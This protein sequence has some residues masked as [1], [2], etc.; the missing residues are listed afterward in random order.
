MTLLRHHSRLLLAALV[1]GLSVPLAGQESNKPVLSAAGGA[2]STEA[3]TIPFDPPIGTPLTYALRFERKRPGGDSVYE[4]EQRLTFARIE[5]GLLL[6]LETLAFIIGGQR[7]DLADCQVMERFPAA[8]RPYL[9]PMSV[10]LDEAGEMVR[11]RDWEAMRASLRELPDAAVKLSDVSDEAAGRAALAQ[12]L[13]PIINA[14]AEDAPA[15]MI[16][17]WPSVLGFGG[18]EVDL[19]ETYEAESEVEGGLLPAS[20]PAVVQFTVTRTPEGK[21]HLF[22]STRYDPE[23]MRAATNAVIDAARAAAVGADK[24]GSGEAFGAMQASDTVDIA[25]DPSSGM[26]ITAEVLRIVS[27]DTGS[28]SGAGGEVMTISRIA[29]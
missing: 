19:G 7:L 16:R 3:V 9:L 1:L 18:I 28:E 2:E 25:L 23:A 6:R 20:I 24:S 13:G 14:S 29:P 17:G 22:Q 27:V 26:P 10:E 11:M 21:L 15:L 12:F 5:G 8:L 4:Y